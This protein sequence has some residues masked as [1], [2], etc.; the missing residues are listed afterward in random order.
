M[1]PPAEDGG[2]PPT[3]LAQDHAFQGHAQDHGEQ[4]GA[5]SVPQRRAPLDGFAVASLIS[6]ILALVPLAV[7]F[8][9]VALARI[10]RTG[11]RGRAL[12]ITG[13][14]LGGAWAIAAA[15]AVA[16][17]ISQRPPARLVTLP[18]VFSLRTGECINSAPN[19]TSGVHVL[20]CGQPHDGEVFATFRLAGQHYPG[21][22]AVRQQTNEGC[23]SRLSGYMN[24]QLSTMLNESY[25]YPGSAAWAAGERTVVC[26]VRGTN[27]KLIGSVRTMP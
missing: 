10:A 25:A 5:V 12:A 8:G 26:T 14:T 3:A 1:N 16:M 23:G 19:G 21:A 6:G 27:G 24:P 17:I 13:L 2:G 4:P 20:A 18:K 22:A 15:L 11:A 7:I 9:P